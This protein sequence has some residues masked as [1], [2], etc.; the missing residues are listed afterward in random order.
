MALV[1]NSH[2]LLRGLMIGLSPEQVVQQRPKAGTTNSSPT[3]SMPPRNPG[4][5]GKRPRTLSL[6]SSNRRARK[7]RRSRANSLATRPTPF[8]QRMITEIFLKQSKDGEND[9]E[10]PKNDVSE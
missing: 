6:A 2:G 4:S 8:G 1:N 9:N 5:A 10:K 7:G 3:P